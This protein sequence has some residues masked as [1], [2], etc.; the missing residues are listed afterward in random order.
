MRAK[1]GKREIGKERRPQMPEE[2]ESNE[3]LK[4]S[5]I[6]KERVKP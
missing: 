6:I 4:D 5:E 1:R 3:A 2:E